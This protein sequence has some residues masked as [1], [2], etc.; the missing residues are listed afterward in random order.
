MNVLLITAD[1]LRYDAIGA[2]GAGGALT[3]SIDRIAAEGVFFEKAYTPCPICVPARASITTGN[4]P[5]RATGT[6]RNSGLIKDD[7]PRIAHHFN[8]NGYETYAI[9]KLHYV[10]YAAPGEKRLLHGFKYCELCESGR[11][12]NQ[13]GMVENSLGIEDYHDY[14]YRHGYG[15]YERAHGMGNNEVF[16]TVSMLPEDLYVDTWVAMRTLDTLEMHVQEHADRPFFMWMSFPKPHSPYDPPGRWAEAYD[17]REVPEP[18][19]TREMLAEK[20]PVMRGWPAAFMWDKL[21]PEGIRAAKARYYGII[22]HQ[23]DRIRVLL[24]FLEDSGLAEN[25]IVCYT[26]DHGDMMGDFGCFFKS[27][28]YEGS[29][30][31]PFIWRVPGIAG[32]RRTR[33]LAGLQDILPTLAALTGTELS[34]DVHGCDLTGVLKGG[35]GVRDAYVSQVADDPEQGYMITDGRYKYIY[36]QTGA[37]EELYD[38]DEDPQELA[39]LVRRGAGRE[40]AEDL[41]GKLVEW[42]KQYG[43]TAML[44]KSGGLVSSPAP[45]QKKAEPRPSSWGKRWY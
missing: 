43:D 12:I 20:D 17:P 18:A 26:T 13:Y 5:H 27:N 33:E 28:F 6:K 30:R 31:I 21:S 39:D 7:Q 10:P 35:G 15:G 3:P 1:Q 14:L 41:R 37:H 23:D 29:A 2:A 22:S 11:I 42:L 4:Y 45:V 9:G 38:L 25:T 8:D 40:K 36:R 34:H 16:A 44:D 32:G 24:E 19:G